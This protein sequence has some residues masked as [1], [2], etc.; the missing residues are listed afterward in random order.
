LRTLKTRLVPNHRAGTRV[1]VLGASI[2]P[3]VR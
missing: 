2:E 1:H 3:I